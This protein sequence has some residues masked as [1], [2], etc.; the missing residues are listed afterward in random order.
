MTPEELLAEFDNYTFDY[1]MNQCLSR[2]PQ[3]LDT[4]EGAI[5]FDAIAPAAWSFTEIALNVKNVLLNTYTQTAQ[6][7]FLDYRAQ[8]KGLTRTPATFS[9][10]K[11]TFTDPDGKPFNVATGLRFSSIG[12]TAIYY[13]VVSKIVDGQFTLRATQVGNAGNRYLGQILPVDNISGLGYATIT[14]V[15][16]PA[17]DE[18]TDDDL[19]GRILGDAGLVEYGGNIADYLKMV[20]IIGDVGA[21]QIYPTWN[22]GG[23]VRVVILDNNFDAASTTLVAEVQNH[24]DPTGSGLAGNGYGLAPIGHTVTVAAPT[25]KVVNITMKVT[26]ESGATYVD[27]TPSIQT[28]LTDFFLNLRKKQWATVQNGRGYAMTIFAAQISAVVLAVTGVVNVT[29]LKLNG[30]AGDVVLKFNNTLQE[31]PLLGSVTV[32]G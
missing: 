25:K 9:E 15:T 24:L 5:I 12:D 22:G 6:G 13:E 10:V 18:E 7:V 26:T 27:V 32:N 14:A 17:R 30:G 23:T 21:T 20:S 11:A 4:R 2:V 1:F 29:D 28:A 16:I 3:G 31:V 8:E 19:R